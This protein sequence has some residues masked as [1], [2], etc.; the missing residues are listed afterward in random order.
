[1]SEAH[2]KRSSLTLGQ[3][4]ALLDSDD[5]YYR[6][7][8]RGAS[9]TTHNAARLDDAARSLR[10]TLAKVPGM[11]A[12][13]RLLNFDGVPTVEEVRRL[14]ERLSEEFASE[15]RR[16]LFPELWPLA[17]EN[18]TLP[19][20]AGVLNK[21][22]GHELMRRPEFQESVRQF[23]TDLQDWEERLSPEE[24]LKNYHDWVA[25]TVLDL[26]QLGTPP[27]PDG[28]EAPDKFRWRGNVCGGLSKLQYI[29]LDYLWNEGQRRRSI[30]FE[31]AREGIWGTDLRDTSIKSSVSRLNTK[32]NRDGRPNGIYLGLGTE[33]YN[34]TCTWG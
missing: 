27:G 2:N 9:P 16:I 8:R 31:E 28:P 11:P 18:L 10:D 12:L 24:A 15:V 5:R 21:V 20:A 17:V 13:A 14:R 33:N 4:K 34:I 32:L 30:P 25:E 29:L 26:P 23:L 1:M 6:A 19:D 7:A 22:Q 3:L